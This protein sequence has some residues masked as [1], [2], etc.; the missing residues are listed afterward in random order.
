[1]TTRATLAAKTN[2]LHSHN[3]ENLATQVKIKSIEQLRQC[4]SD[5]QAKYPEHRLFFRGQTK[6]IDPIPSAQRNID[7]LNS[8]KSNAIFQSTWDHASSYLL[9]IASNRGGRFSRLLA[10]MGLL[11]HYGFRSWF[12]DITANPDIAVWFAIHRYVAEKATVMPRPIHKGSDPSSY[13]AD[14]AIAVVNT[15]RY[16]RLAAADGFLFVFKIH[17]SDPNAFL[18]NEVVSSVALRAHRQE[19]CELIPSFYGKPLISLVAARF[20]IDRSIVLPSY[21][22]TRWL[23]PPPSEDEIYKH[24][25]RIPFVVSADESEESPL[26]AYPAILDVPL[27]KYDVDP[28]ASSIDQVRVLIGVYGPPS[29]IRHQQT[30]VVLPV[31]RFPRTTYSTHIDPPKELLPATGVN[32]NLR[33]RQS[34]TRPVDLRVWRSNVL[35]LLYPVH[36]MLPTLLFRDNTYPLFRGLLIEILAN[37]KVEISAIAETLD[38]VVFAEVIPKDKA[39]FLED[40]Y[41]LTE[42]LQTGE[43]QLIQKGPL[44]HYEWVGWDSRNY[45]DPLAGMRVLMQKQKT[46]S[47][48]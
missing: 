31:S 18:L 32:V 9:N 41:F 13:L 34:I 16:E 38:H 33:M 10:S 36:Q 6:G 43:A 42:K 11:Q 28:D 25:L 37:G 2:V 5:I 27:Y 22:D 17:S 20:T 1:M 8:R 35:L 21:L 44:V 45:E 3:T 48:A 40:F 4:I 29:S 23:F 39:W 47:P 24:L 46:M 15:D 19:A 12:I 30:T 14:K 26:F 7:D